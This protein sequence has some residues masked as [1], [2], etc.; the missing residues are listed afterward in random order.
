[1][2]AKTY[3]LWEKEVPFS[4][5]SDN[6]IPA[7]NE[8]PVQNCRNA[9][10]VCPGGGYRY[11]AEHEGTPVAQMMNDAGISAFVLDYRVAPC[12]YRAPVND[13]LR[14]IRLMRYLG[15]EKIAILG[16]SAGGHVACCAV[17]HWPDSFLDSN[18]PVDQFSSRPDGLISCYSVVSMTEYAHQGS[19]QQLLGN[20][21][22]NRELQ[23]YFSAQ[24]HVT[25]DTPP[26]FIWHTSADGSV[27][28][29]NSLMLASAYAK[30]GV[31]FEIHVFPG[32]HHGMGLA[33]NDAVVSGWASLC[34]QWIK[35]NI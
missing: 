26:A 3:K 25:K 7:V 5:E 34:T 31:P 6:F 11:K 33:S 32:G 14:A 9:V 29:E 19:V 28:V 23:E 27:P 17:V 4:S 20:E 10:L 35:N 18:D 15:Y 16:F 2:D 1:M 12:D 13:A 30:N 24:L 21:W 22:K 8:F